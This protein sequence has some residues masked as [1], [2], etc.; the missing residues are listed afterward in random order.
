[1]ARFGRLPRLTFLKFARHKAHGHKVVCLSTTE[2]KATST[3]RSSS[4]NANG[5]D[6]NN[7]RDKVDVEAV[8]DVKEDMEECSN[9]AKKAKTEVHAEASSIN[10]AGISRTGTKPLEPSR[11]VHSAI[12][13]LFSLVSM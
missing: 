10:G 3:K 2:I 7:D 5:A 12:L 4:G 9:K 13:F 1:M 8:E 6:N 11:P